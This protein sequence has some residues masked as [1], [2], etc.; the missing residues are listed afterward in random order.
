MVLIADPVL[1]SEVYN[2]QQDCEN[3][4]NVRPSQRLLLELAFVLQNLNPGH[5][6][7]PSSYKTVQ[8]CTGVQTTFAN[9]P[10]VVHSAHAYPPSLKPSFHLCADMVSSGADCMINLPRCAPT[11]ET[12][13]EIEARILHEMPL[14]HAFP[15][16]DVLS[17][18]H[19]T[20][21][22]LPS[23]NVSITCFYST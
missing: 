12:R 2:N 15:Q 17:A 10:Y 13:V 20:H 7:V 22:P 21:L 14:S 19:N 1:A 8:Q 4:D 9:I 18:E 16:H 3:I 6:L 23:Q 5:I 11:N